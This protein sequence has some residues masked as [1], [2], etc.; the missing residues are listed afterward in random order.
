MKRNLR[1]EDEKIISEFCRQE[2]LESFYHYFPLMY[3][4]SESTHQLKIDE[5]DNVWADDEELYIEGVAILEEPEKV[6]KIWVTLQKAPWGWKSELY[7]VN[8]VYDLK[9]TLQ[10]KNFRKN[11]KKFLRDNGRLSYGEP[12]D[13]KECWEVVKTWYE[14]SNRKAFTDFGYTKWL[15]ENYHR[16]NP[17]HPRVVSRDGKP[18]ALSLWGELTEETAIHLICKD[19]RVPYLQD[20]IRHM[21]YSE[22]LEKGFETVNDGGNCGEQGID[23]FK[24]KLRPKFILPVWSWIRV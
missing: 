4:I 1:I 2:A 13:S 7:D 23:V 20:Y 18:L 5:Q 8:F 24:Q 21:T 11:V 16:F 19:V 6:K 3:A 14:K 12:F 22:M 9:T 15:I 17:I 10:I